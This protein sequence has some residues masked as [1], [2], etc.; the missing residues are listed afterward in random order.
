M[1]GKTFIAISSL[2]VLAVP[3]PTS[4]GSIVAS[5][6]DIS[7]Y[8]GFTQAA[9]DGQLDSKDRQRIIILSKNK[10]NHPKLIDFA[11]VLRQKGYFI[12]ARS[13]V[14]RVLQ[15]N[16]SNLDARLSAANLSQ[17]E[18]N[19]AVAD[20]GDDYNA[21]ARYLASTHGMELAERTLKEYSELINSDGEVGTKA[22]LNWIRF[23]SKLSTKI[24]NIARLKVQNEPFFRQIVLRISDRLQNISSPEF[25][26][27][28]IETLVNIRAFSDVTQSHT[29]QLLSQI[30]RNSQPRSFSRALGIGGLLYKRNGDLTK[31]MQYLAS[32]RTMSLAIGA[33][34]LSSQWE[35]EMGRL[36]YEQHD[37]LNAKRLY[38]EAFGHIND[39]R[40]GRFSLPPE[41]QYQAEARFI[42][43]YRS[44]QDL[45]FSEK[46]LN[47]EEI[48]TVQEQQKVS[49]I[50]NYLNCGKLKTVSLLSLSTSR[51]PDATIY[52]IRK[53][54]QYELVLRL[55]D[56]RF[57][58]QSVD[59]AQLNVTLNEARK[60]LNYGSLINIQSSDIKS[61]FARLYRL[62]LGRVSNWLPK[63]GSVV[64]I[65]DTNVQNI[66]WDALVTPQGKFLIE[67]YSV[68]YSVG[69]TFDITDTREQNKKSIFVGGVSHKSGYQ[70][71]PGVMSEVA[72]IAKIFPDAR[73]LLNQAFTM[74][75]IIGQAK[76][77]DI[78][79]LATHGR[80]SRNPLQTYIVGW[81]G[82]I[83]LKVFENFIQGRQKPI[84]LLFLSACETAKGDSRSTLGISGTAVRIRAKSAIATLWA[85]DDMA[86]SQ[87]AVNF[88]KAYNAGRSEAD[89]L[90]EAK[91]TALRSP[92]SIVSNF[93][94]VFGPIYVGL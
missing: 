57:Y 28:L 29:A 43:F 23:W 3:L 85:M 26:L 78:I 27:N 14:D 38:R 7:A 49:E 62:T 83:N 93:A 88:Y 19:Y 9:C 90:R 66:P 51:L 72:N 30:D 50:E 75:K 55:K 92:D 74:D 44:Y 21:D 33:I 67:Q 56:G 60:F 82:S 58:H 10:I 13:F 36:F 45:L 39:L 47:Y 81:E 73:V 1:I 91:L 77:A 46:N 31:A 2:A 24:P 61:T 35:I 20:L 89:A 17:S 40:E 11:V 34:D 59:A 68:G 16:P 76:Y 6:S 4:A 25:K 86:M 52:L 42:S 32:A 18:Y 5:C 54:N 64:M 41:V 71:L 80:F 69:L 65:V 37:Q 87:F 63:S 94:N 53:S 15:N 48:I 70:S 8:L 22:S 84:N 79:H 12:P